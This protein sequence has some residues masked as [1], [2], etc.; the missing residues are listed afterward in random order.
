M[1]NIRQRCVILGPQSP[2][3]DIP[4]A[5]NA[6]NLT[7][8]PLHFSSLNPINPPESSRR[9]PIADYGLDEGEGRPVILSA[10]SRMSIT[11]PKA[12]STLSGRMV[13]PSSSRKPSGPSRLDL[14]FES[15]VNMP[16]PEDL[17]GPTTGLRPRLIYIRDFPTLAPSSSSWYPSLLNAVRQRRRG[18]SRPYTSAPV[19]IIFGMSPSIANPV[20]ENSPGS[21]TSLFSL[22]M[23]RNLPSHLS[24]GG[25]L[26][27]ANDFSESDNAQAAREKRLLSR[28]RKWDKNPA[29]LH[30][31]FPK[32]RTRTEGREGSPL[33]GIILIGG[34]N[35]SSSMDPSG[36]AIDVSAA[37]PEEDHGSQ[38]FRSTVLVPRSRSLLDERN[39]RMSRRRQINELTM[40]MGIGAIGGVIESS[41][42]FPESED[43]SSPS[44]APKT[45]MWEEWGN[46][47]ES[48]SSVRKISDRAIGSVLVQQY[49][50]KYEKKS[51]VV[52]LVSWNAVQSAWMACNQLGMTRA[53]WLKETFGDKMDTKGDHEDKTL[54]A[55]GSTSDQVVENLR[56]DPDLDPY[57]ARLLPCIVDAS[58]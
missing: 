1:G 40:R 26:D 25:K 12:L 42:A 33:P 43:V 20:N 31:E 28:L 7:P 16:C 18:L 45:P 10:P 4:K 14:F 13:M 22:L 30:A 39:S 44:E 52:T 41:P 17:L 57:E 6:L 27:V 3:L 24:Q 50:L 58:G 53:M 35:G 19:T 36:M 51:S 21:K 47:L 8:N 49:G 29:A 48:W 55:P 9:R 23:S 5:A 15:L 34:P 54:R 46:K 11:I 2:L 56:N 37:H 32:L 38:F